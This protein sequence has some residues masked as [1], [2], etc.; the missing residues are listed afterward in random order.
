MLSCLTLRGRCPYGPWFAEDVRGRSREVR[1]GT[2]GAAQGPG[3]D[4]RELKAQ[5][6]AP[7]YDCKPL[8][9]G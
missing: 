2:H 4:H 8:A 7:T 6:C 1:L 5:H 3:G 9:N